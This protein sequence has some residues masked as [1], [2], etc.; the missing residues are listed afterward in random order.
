MTKVY[1]FLEN[2]SMKTIFYL[3]LCISLNVFAVPNEFDVNHEIKRGGRPT[4]SDLDTLKRDGFKT[5]INL[6]NK[7]EVISKEKAYAKK[8]GFNYLVSE[9]DTQ[10]TPND[11]QIEK[12]LEV[13][14]D[15][16]QQPVYIHCFHGQDR[17]GMVIG[18][19]RVLADHWSQD[20][21][22]KEMVNLGF[23]PKYIKLKNY[24]LQKTQTQ[25]H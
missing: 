7:A 14:M 8:L 6:E 23:H 1:V 9:L 20:E 18:I 2:Q 12:V 21:A 25:K 16:S 3:V 4:M 11:Q 17:T 10:E 22:Y 13:L 19:Y 15:P 5:I 24:F